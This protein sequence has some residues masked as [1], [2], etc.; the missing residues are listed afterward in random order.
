MTK[1]AGISLSA[2]NLTA[3]GE[4]M[5]EFEYAI[6]GKP[7]GLWF[8]VYGTQTDRVQA[9]INKAV[10]ER[11]K[12]EAVA[13]S[14]ARHSRAG[15]AEFTPLEDDTAFGQRLAAVRLGGWRGPGQTEDLTP[16]QK[17]RFQ[18]ITEP[19]SPELALKLCQGNPDIAAQAT[20]EANRT[21]NFL[22]L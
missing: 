2:L 19:F 7:S 1:P 18:G 8:S 15:A 21:S 16:E 5:F 14:R 12:T 9:A 20:E 22:K 3:A 17:G 11:R 4:Q 13:E 6:D 10:N